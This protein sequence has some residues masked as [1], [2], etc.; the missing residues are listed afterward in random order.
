MTFFSNESETKECQMSSQ[1]ITTESFKISNR[2]DWLKW[3]VEDVTAS[4]I[5]ALFKAPPTFKSALQVYL[6]KTEGPQA[7]IDNEAMR[8][9]R[10]LEPAA[11]EA[12]LEIRPDWK[13]K[14][15]QSY[16][17]SPQHRLGATPDLVNQ[18]GE[19]IEVKAP[20]G[21]GINKWD[22]EPPLGYQL[23]NLTQSMLMGA[24]R[25]WVLCLEISSFRARAELFEVERNPSA[26]TK[27]IEAVADFWGR[28]A[29]MDPPA[30]D[31]DLDAQ[32]VLRAYPADDGTEIDLTS[33]NR[34]PAIL[35]ELVDLKIDRK[36]IVDRI[37]AIETETKGKIGSAEYALVN[38]FDL[39]WKTQHRKSFTVQ[40]N[41]IRVLRVK[42]VRPE[43][44]RNAA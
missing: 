24:P 43:S 41:D 44:A 14:R 17:R 26:E 28:V 16:V 35:A 3:R 11:I 7:D 22:G 6:E 15:P 20:L 1:Q 9:G 42:D 13:I 30:I 27:I 12:L 37:K 39:S 19:P 31:P 25:G 4:D 5:G 29:R 36:V 21:D 18:Y 40:A 2:D 23:Q 34:L 32:T 38:G 8:R 33:D 10:W